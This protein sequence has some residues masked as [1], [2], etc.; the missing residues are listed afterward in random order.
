MNIDITHALE[1][2]DNSIFIIEGSSENNASAI[3]EEYQK[4]NPS[5]EAAIIP[6]AKHFPHIENSKKFIEQLKVFL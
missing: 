5:I 3:I 2:I 4:V 1:T 6:E